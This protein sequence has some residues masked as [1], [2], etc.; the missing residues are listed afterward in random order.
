M[1]DLVGA[2]D[3]SLAEAINVKLVVH[4]DVVARLVRWGHG[5]VV[6]W[7]LLVV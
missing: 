3:Q 2:L 7:W 4:T 6:A 1:T 5:G